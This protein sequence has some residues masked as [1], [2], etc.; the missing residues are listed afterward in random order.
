MDE[1][2]RGFARIRN[3]H[4]QEGERERENRADG[5]DGTVQRGN[6]GSRRG[7]E[8]GVSSGCMPRRGMKR[9]SVR[10]GVVECVGV[11][12]LESGC[13][14]AVDERAMGGE[15]RRRRPRNMAERERIAKSEWGYRRQGWA[16]RV[17]DVSFSVQW[18]SES[19]E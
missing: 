11:C 7:D 13:S 12:A 4:A 3:A 15:A 16:W 5:S 10:L 17:V 18:T 6:Q 9:W 1:K 2:G 19:E 8:G 14:L